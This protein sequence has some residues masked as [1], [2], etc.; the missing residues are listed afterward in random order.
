MALIFVFG[1][2]ARLL[3]QTGGFGVIRGRVYNSATNEYVRNA[4]VRIEAT[5]QTAYSGE[6]GYYNLANVPA[7]EVTL[8]VTYTGTQSSREVLNVTAGGTT[9]HDVE[10]Q[11]VVYQ[12]P[13]DST[14]KVVKLDTF[15][16][17]SERYGQAKAIMEQRVALNAKNVV[18]SDNYGDLTM[19]DVGEFLKS[20][21]GISLDYVE[22]DTSAVRIGG[23][24]PKYSIFT[25][26]GVRMPTGTS[27]NNAGRQNS[28]EQMSIT[29]IETIRDGRSP[30]NSV[31]SGRRMPP[32][33]ANIFPTTGSTAGFFP[34]A[35]LAIATY[36]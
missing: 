4:E 15:V 1:G 7:G 22:V 29:G 25:T 18:A 13:Q 30:F 33:P 8:A 26:D 12:K 23:L 21:P 36:S 9:V 20:M 31:V 5:G 24:D 19:G 17:S 3:A 34:A 11:G 27:N 35:R 16:V 14:G 6:G 10:L 28:F 2:N 32:S